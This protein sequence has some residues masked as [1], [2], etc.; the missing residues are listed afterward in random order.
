MCPPPGRLGRLF[1]RLVF[2]ASVVFA[3][4]QLMVDESQACDCVHIADEALRRV[5]I[6]LATLPAIVAT[7]GRAGYYHGVASIRPDEPCSV[8]I[9]EFVHHDQWL[10]GLEA[11][12]VGDAMWWALEENAKAI[13]KRALENGGGQC[14]ATE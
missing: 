2:W 10:R 13:E 12:H 1:F 7:T 8:Y 14:D 9:H 4:A 3:I 5:G 6:R 11:P